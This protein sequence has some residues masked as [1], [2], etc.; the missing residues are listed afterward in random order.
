MRNTLIVL[1]AFVGLATGCPVLAHHSFSAEFDGSKLIELKD[2]VTK[3][4]GQILT[5]ISI[6]T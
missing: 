4:F 5:S 1:A 3:I 2:V 6:L